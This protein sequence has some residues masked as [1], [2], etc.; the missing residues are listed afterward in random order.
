MFFGCGQGGG[1]QRLAYP[2][3]TLIDD[4]AQKI[5]AG[6]GEVLDLGNELGP[7]PMYVRDSVEKGLR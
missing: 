6:L 4:L 2:A 1:A 7:H 5:V 3:Q